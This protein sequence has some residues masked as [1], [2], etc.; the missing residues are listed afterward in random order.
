M[1]CDPLIN[2]IGTYDLAAMTRAAR[3]PL[4]L[5]AMENDPVGPV[6]G[7]RRLGRQVEVLPGLGHNPHVEAPRVFWRAI[8]E[9]LLEA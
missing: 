7:M 8:A 9:A 3:A 5:L 1:A 6:A 2:S 4:R